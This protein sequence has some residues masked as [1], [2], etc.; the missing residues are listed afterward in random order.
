[1]TTIT[2]RC[3]AAERIR[4]GGGGGGKYCTVSRI[5]LNGAFNTLHS[6][7]CGEEALY[8]SIYFKVLPMYLILIL[9]GN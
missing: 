6:S 4:G 9:I 1:M 3:R 8:L 5:P 2:P 7:R